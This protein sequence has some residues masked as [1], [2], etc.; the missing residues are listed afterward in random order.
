MLGT[1]CPGAS[2]W[3]VAFS[4]LLGLIPALGLELDPLAL[5]ELQ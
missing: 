5:S 3:A 1:L 2:A 4:Q